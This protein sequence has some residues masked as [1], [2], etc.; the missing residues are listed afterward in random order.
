MTT[1]DDTIAMDSAVFKTM[2]KPPR[3]PARKPVRQLTRFEL[4]AWSSIVSFQVG[5]TAGYLT[6]IYFGVASLFASP[7]SITMTTPDWYEWYWAAALTLGAALASFGSVAQKSR[8]FQR[9]ETIGSSL[10]SLTVVS[11]ASIMSWLAYAA[12]EADRIA[13]SAGFV[14]LA[15]PIVIRTMWLYSQLLRK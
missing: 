7:P 3:V 12:G 14:A 15:T 11:Y 2:P 9:I 8:L 4:W 6:L 10:L 13:G 5:L 1:H